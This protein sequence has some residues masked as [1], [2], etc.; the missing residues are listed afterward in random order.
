MELDYTAPSVQVVD[1]ILDELRRDE[2]PLEDI[3]ETLFGFGCYVGEV[4]VRNSQGSWRSRLGR[5]EHEIYEF[6]FVI[7]LSG[8][9]SCDPIGKAF[10]RFKNG[11]EDSLMYFYTIFCGGLA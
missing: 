3:A 4:M 8:S 10:K 11:S 2:V 7:Q 9:R 1:E 6:P 5:I